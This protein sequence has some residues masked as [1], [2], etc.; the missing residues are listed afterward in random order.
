DKEIVIVDDGSTDTS[1]SLISS[2]QSAHADLSVKTLSKENGGKGSAVREG[3]K[4]STGSIV[5]I[6]DADLEYDPGDYQKCIDPILSASASVVYGSREMFTK[7]RM[8]SSWAFYLGGLTVTFM[9]N[10]LYLTRLTD[11]PTCYKTFDGDLIR[12]LLFE[13]DRFDWEPEITAKLLRLGFKI[14]EVPISYFPRKVED[15]KKINW[16]DGVEALYI[17]LKW[18]FKSIKSDREKLLGW[19]KK[20]GT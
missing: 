8:H 7:N 5:I 17:A 1:W 3:I 13:G 18:R 4:L 12:L 14:D 11:E 20:T 9:F 19:T 16:K 6:Q 10:I 2:W 15:G